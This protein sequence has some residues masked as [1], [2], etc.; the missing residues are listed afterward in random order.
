MAKC[1]SCGFDKLRKSDARCPDCHAW[2]MGCEASTAISPLDP[3]GTNGDGVVLLSDIIDVEQDRYQ[4]GPWD[5]VLGGGIVKTSIILLGGGPGAGKTT[6]CLQLCDAF[7]RVT[8]RIPLYFGAE[9]P[10]TEVRLTAKRMKLQGIGAIHYFNAMGGRDFSL[11][12]IIE[13]YKPPLVVVD[14]INGLVGKDLEQQVSVCESLKVLAGQYA[15]PHVVISQVNKNEDFAG[16]KKLQ[17]VVDAL[18][19]IIIRPD[20]K[21]RILGIDEKNR[22]GPTPREQSYDMTEIGLVHDE[23]EDEEEEEGEDFDGPDDSE[24]DD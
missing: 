15:T 7:A 3:Q 24:E 12:E 16:L 21:K 23:S 8:N 5:H 19:T 4:T 1:W 22:F 10:G 9:Q 2:N 13:K 6:L 20:D 17:H 18:V 14:S 11:Q